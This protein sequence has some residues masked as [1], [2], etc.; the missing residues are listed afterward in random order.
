MESDESGFVAPSEHVTQEDARR[1]IDMARLRL[2]MQREN[3]PAILTDDE[4]ADLSWFR[5]MRYDQEKR[6]FIVS[7]A[8]MKKLAE[9]KD[10]RAWMKW[11]RESAEQ[12][13]AE[14]LALAEEEIKR[15]VA[16]GDINRPKWK[17]RIRLKTN[18]HFIRP[19]AIKAWNKMETP[20]KWFFVDKKKTD[21]MIVE[22]LLPKSVQGTS[23]YDVGLAYAYR[24]VVAL[25]IGSQG[26]FWFDLPLQTE[27]FDESIEDIE[28]GALLH[29]GRRV[30]RRVERKIENLNIFWVAVAFGLLPHDGPELAAFR[31]YLGGLMYWAK[32]D[33]HSGFEVQ[34][35]RAFFDSFQ[36]ATLL[37]GDW[38]GK[39]PFREAATKVLTPH[40]KN[41]D[42]AVEE[43]VSLA[44]SYSPGQTLPEVNIEQAAVM[45]LFTDVY[46]LAGLDRVAR[47]RASQAKPDR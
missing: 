10:V 3:E 42:E 44:D 19:K 4:R 27:R 46:L 2:E 24:F 15:E 29:V 32:T 1:L 26:F 47:H 43:I 8:S 12:R 14:L 13:D 6:D 37:F 45:K 33:I 28:T 30:A 7:G 17:F 35:F 5:A 41:V 31:H 18:S 11:L 39:E 25:N 22:F 40:V 20:I 36:T 38:D 9:L 16:D 21:Q 34:A 23:L